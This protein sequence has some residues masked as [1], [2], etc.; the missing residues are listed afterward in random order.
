M[1]THLPSS[2]APMILTA[3]ILA[4]S[5]GALVIWFSQRPTPASSPYPRGKLCDLNDKENGDV[6]KVSD[7]PDGW[8]T[9]PEVF[10]CE[11]R[12]IFAQVRSLG[13]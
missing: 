9:S 5:V 10:E 8:W 1:V 7:L 6:K 12:A 4:A 2:A 11:Q 13:Y 3:G